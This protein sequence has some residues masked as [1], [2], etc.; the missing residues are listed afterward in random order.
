MLHQKTIIL[1]GHLLLFV[2]KYFRNSCAYYILLFIL[3]LVTNM[4]S[5]LLKQG[6]CEFIIYCKTIW[7][8]VHDR[9]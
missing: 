5:P 1:S 7:L 8:K 3:L 9:L 2:Y 4:Q 6:I